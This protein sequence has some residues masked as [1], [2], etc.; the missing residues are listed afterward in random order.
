MFIT[1]ILKFFKS[2]KLM[3]GMN[4]T[5]TFN[6]WLVKKNILIKFILYFYKVK[7]ENK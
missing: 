1:I 2:L 4:T 3:S 6:I 5:F 7:S